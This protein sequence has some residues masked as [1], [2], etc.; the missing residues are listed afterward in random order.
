MIYGPLMNEASFEF[1]VKRQYQTNE[2]SYAHKSIRF[3]MTFSKTLNFVFILFFRCLT[4]F[5]RNW[6]MKIHCYELRHQRT[7]K[8]IR[9]GGGGGG[10]AY[11]GRTV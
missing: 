5:K 10:G 9:A 8:K 6:V 3:L 11:F 2:E 7:Q 4:G 1:L